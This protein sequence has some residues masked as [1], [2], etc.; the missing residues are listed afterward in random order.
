MVM[1]RMARAGAKKKLEFVIVATSAR[2]KRDGKYLERLGKYYPRAKDAA[3]KLQ[4]D[5]ARLD[6]WLAKGATMSQ[7]VGQLVKTLPQ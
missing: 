2:G 4:V 3:S 1:I 7:T 6:A 5:K